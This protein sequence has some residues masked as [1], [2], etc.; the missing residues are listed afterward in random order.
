MSTLQQ[1]R[2]ATGATSDRQCIYCWNR[3]ESDRWSEEHILPKAI[4]GQSHE[5]N[6]FITNDVCE[7][8]N[9]F[10]GRYVDARYVRS[11][12]T[13]KAR[14]GLAWRT[15]DLA[16]RPA[17]PL[18][19]V[20]LVAQP[21]VPEGDVCEVWWGPAQDLIYHIHHPYPVEPDTIPLVG[22]PVHLP[23]EKVDP[24]LTFLVL[25]TTN[26][27]W[28]P[29]VLHSVANQFEGA[30]LY[31]MNVFPTTPPPYEPIPDHLHS[32]RDAIMEHAQRPQNTAM[33]PFDLYFAERLEA[34]VAL[35]IGALLLHP[36]F[37]SSDDAEQLRKILFCKDDKKRENL[38]V[39]T[40]MLEGHAEMEKILTWT[41]VQAT[42]VHMLM[43]RSFPHVVL[44]ALRLYGGP[45]AIRPISRTPS[46]WEGRLSHSGILYV[47]APG[48]Q[49]YIGPIPFEQ[50]LGWKLNQMPQPELDD[51]K[52]RMDEIPKVVPPRV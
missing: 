5:A 10:C 44:F 48:L 45:V 7:W 37:R 17:L 27:K 12:L 28:H 31:L 6:P 35:G 24:G 40:G 50:F 18:A 52:R 22:R 13:N 2:D 14:A 3:Q 30:K 25:H 36:S 34:K 20:G 1:T 15:V 46:H 21:W 41:G 47:I 8:C 42:D 23:L 32:L 26:E 49:R 43:I 9:N 4:A 29:T 11:W 38:L 33:A 39:G 51:F 19:Y 16:T